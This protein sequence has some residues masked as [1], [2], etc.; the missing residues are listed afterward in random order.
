MSAYAWPAIEAL[1]TANN[2]INLPPELCD[3]ETLNQY[4]EL[5]SYD[6]FPDMGEPFRF[7]NYNQADFNPPSTVSRT[8]SSYSVSASKISTELDLLDQTVKIGASKSEV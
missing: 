6:S 7:E 3:I 5:F 4:A 1:D 8:P 2:P